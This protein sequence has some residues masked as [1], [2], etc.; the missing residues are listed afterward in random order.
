MVNVQNVFL[1]FLLK[2]TILISKDITFYFKHISLNDFFYKINSLHEF[3]IYIKHQG[4]LSVLHKKSYSITIL[5][6]SFCKI[7][8]KNCVSTWIVKN[9]CSKTGNNW[10]LHFWAQDQVV[11]RRWLSWN[12]LHKCTFCIQSE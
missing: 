10:F 1:L 8:C 12:F 9:T 3:L 5:K 7:W 6:F 2:N 4:K 11:R